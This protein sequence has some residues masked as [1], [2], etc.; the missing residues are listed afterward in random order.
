M[1]KTIKNIHFIGI[2]G[3]GM[4]GIAI[5]LHNLG[6]LV[7]GSDLKHSEVIHDLEKMGIKVSIGHL[8]ENVS[9][10]HVAVYSSAVGNKNVEI[11][12]AKKKKIPVIPRA[13]ML[14]E[15]ARLK[16]AITI[17]GTHG[18]TT[19]TSLLSQ[20]LDEA[21]LDPTIIVGGKLKSL[22]SGAKLGYGEYLVAEADESDGSFLKLSPTI[23]LV[24]NID[25][26]HMDYYQ[27]FEKL[28]DAFLKHINAVPFYGFS[29]LCID[30]PV[31]NVLLPLI[32]RKYVTYSVKNSADYTAKNIINN[33]NSTTFTVFKNNKSLGQIE[34]NLFGIHNVSNALGVAACASELGIDIKAIS[35]ALKKF[36]GVGRRLE[37][38]GE[39]EGVYY[40]DDYAHHPTEITATVSAL[41]ERYPKKR[42][43]CVFQPHRFSR[44]QLL[45]NELAESL[46][47]I[48]VLFLTEI[49]AA[50]EN[51][52]DR[53]S[54]ELI[55]RALE[56]K[57]KNIRII[58][59]ND[60]EK[61]II[62]ELKEGDVFLTM[63]AGNINKFNLHLFDDK[64]HK[65]QVVED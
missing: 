3:A 33:K 28:K 38:I 22:G 31:I 13:E 35:K 53:V 27:S 12:E 37:F 58:D 14:A 42:I 62:N 25:N 48:D 1:F 54:S 56:R 10:A 50:G 63:G 59:L 23:T 64:E 9:S 5:V 55:K 2:G 4:S 45:Y 8:A 44:T 24:T 40:F 47:N 16:Y 46:K 30:D 60:A 19:T 52:I 65:F 49:Y 17:A 29:V 26:D 43:V 57:G 34:L 18:K 20:V 39:K 32:Q 36:S 51:K 61:D 15:I 41:R 7:T 21:D 11:I 6:Y